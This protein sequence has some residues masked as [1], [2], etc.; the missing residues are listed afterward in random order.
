MSARNTTLIAYDPLLGLCIFRVPRECSNT[1]RQAGR[2]VVAAEPWHQSLQN[3]RH[4]NQPGNPA[5]DLMSTSVTRM[6]AVDAAKTPGPSDDCD[7][8]KHIPVPVFITL[9]R[10]EA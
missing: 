9:R 1:A 6:N 7:G 2:T 8:K 5:P 3:L 4:A 10:M